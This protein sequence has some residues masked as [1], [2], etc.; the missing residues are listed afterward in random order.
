LVEP[1]ETDERQYELVREAKTPIC[2]CGS[3]KS[4]EGWVVRWRR[5]CMVGTAGEWGGSGGGQVRDEEEQV[6]SSGALDREG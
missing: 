3:R 6:V 5:R 2:A 4:M 1:D